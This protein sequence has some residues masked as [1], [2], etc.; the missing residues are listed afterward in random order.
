MGRSSAYALR[1]RL[2]GEPFDLAWQAALRC[3]FD[4]LAEVALE[5][6]IT[7]DWSAMKRMRGRARA[8]QTMATARMRE[9]VLGKCPL[10]PLRSL[11]QLHP[12]ASRFRWKTGA[13]MTTL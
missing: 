1:A 3:R 5:R 11:R 10:C 9:F 7:G 6:A 12:I 13:M 8:T 4:G 2:K